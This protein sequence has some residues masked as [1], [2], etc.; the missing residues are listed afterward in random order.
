MIELG[1]K[2]LRLA[3]RGATL[4]GTGG[5]GSYE[6]GLGF[7]RKVKEARVLERE[8]VK[9]SDTFVTSYLV[10]ALGARVS[11]ESIL[12]SVRTFESIFR[13]RTAGIMFG[14]IG[15]GV[16]GMNFLVSS[17]LGIPLVD[18]D[19]AGG[20]SVPL[21][22][23][24]I[25]TVL[26][27]SRFP[28]VVASQR[29]VLIINQLEPSELEDRIAS[30]VK[31]ESTKLAVSVTGY[32]T[33]GEILLKFPFGITRK[34]IE[35]GRALRDGR[36]LPYFERVGEGIV[37]EVERASSERLL[38]GK[39]LIE[40]EHRWEVLFANENICLLRDGKLFLTVPEL[41]SLVSRSKGMGLCNDELQEGERVEICVGRS[42][43]FWRSRKGL[44]TFNPRILGFNYPIKL[45]QPLRTR[46][47][48]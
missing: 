34:C 41:I 42:Y 20:R 47:R 44:R 22:S 7:A 18:V 2:E 14:E 23:T 8:D 9:R 3:M 25:Y 16:F 37:K 45:L 19:V 30:F 12:L 24:E 36:K 33:Q 26:G 11:M 48:K 15:A 38:R 10:G 1:R 29:S 28:L 13:Q 43:E 17:M 46:Q 39:A 21:I 5:G 6:L 27:L 32:P 4:F 31:S 40:G 35:V